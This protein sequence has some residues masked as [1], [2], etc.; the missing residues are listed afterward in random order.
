M[1]HH[2]YW[3]TP[4]SIYLRIIGSEQLKLIPTD[5]EKSIVTLEAFINCICASRKWQSQKYNC[6]SY[7]RTTCPWSSRISPRAASDRCPCPWCSGPPP[8]PRTVGGTSPLSVH[9]SPPG[10]LKTVHK[11]RSVQLV[12]AP[13]N[14]VFQLTLFY[15][16]K[17]CPRDRFAEAEFDIQR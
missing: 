7:L 14:R 15:W 13:T 10:W 11:K 12:Y 4:F 3:Q 1:L 6:F 9:R 8:P 17:R 16:T 2:F 5:I